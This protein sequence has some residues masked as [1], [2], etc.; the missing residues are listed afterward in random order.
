MAE[1]IFDGRKQKLKL[2]AEELKIALQICDWRCLIE[3]YLVFKR[4]KLFLIN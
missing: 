1:A 2:T 4:K 3:N